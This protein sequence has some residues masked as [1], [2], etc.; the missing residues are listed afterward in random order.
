MFTL[1][2]RTIYLDGL[3][4]LTAA[5]PYDQ[6]GGRNIAPHV[7]DATLRAFVAL[8]NEYPGTFEELL[9]KNLA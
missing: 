6:D 1:Q 3:P 2:D 4:I 9:Q 5:I 8:A 7:F